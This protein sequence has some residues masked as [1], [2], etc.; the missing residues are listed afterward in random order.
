MTL[1]QLRN[2][3][4]K[5]LDQSYLAGK[6]TLG[7]NE[8]LAQLLDVIDVAWGKHGVHAGDNTTSLNR[9][10]TLTSSEVTCVYLFAMRAH[11][12]EVIP[13]KQIVQLLL[14]KLDCLVIAKPVGPV[15]ALILHSFI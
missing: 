14:I 7:N 3:L 2:H 12:I 6:I 9:C 15:E 10:Q 4:L 13:I 8:P 11:A 5:L 1:G